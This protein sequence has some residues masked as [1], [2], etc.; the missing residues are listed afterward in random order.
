MR[1]GEPEHRDGL[2][3]EQLVDPSSVSRGDLLERRERARDD[4]ARR[5]DVQRL[6]DVELGDAHGHDLPRKLGRALDDLRRCGAGHQR[7]VVLED[8]AVKGAELLARL[9]PRLLDDRQARLLVGGERVLPAVRTVQRDHLE[10][11]EP[12]VRRVLAH[13]PVELADRLAMLPE[14]ELRLQPHLLRV[15]ALLLQVADRIL[16]EV[17]VGQVG[18][19][20]P[21]PQLERLPEGSGALAAPAAAAPRA[22][23]A[24]T[25]AR[26]SNRGRHGAGTPA[27]ASPLSPSRSPS[28]ASTRSSGRMPAPSAAASR[29]TTRRS[30]RR[31]VRRRSRSGAAAPP[32]TLCP[33][34]ERHGNA[35]DP[36][37]QRAEH[38]NFDRCGRH[39]ARSPYA[40]ESARTRRE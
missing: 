3:A 18:E 31:A 32:G 1:G 2:L 19:R 17:R 35:V 37:F 14:L 24:R 29:P 33:P 30:A 10:P 11:A 9:E 21:P 8:P 28:A 6:V 12:L 20:R 15:D 38:A 22:R 39:A 26:R 36:H 5:L 40:R 25:A 34:A 7:R 4:A 13:Q 27:P 16:R 23:A